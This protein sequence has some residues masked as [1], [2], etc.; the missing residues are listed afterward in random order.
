MWCNYW[1]IVSV[2][3][4]FSYLL[5][6]HC[7]LVRVHDQR[8]NMHMWGLRLAK[9]LF[10][11]SKVRK[12]QGSI[13]PQNPVGTSWQPRL[14]QSPILRSKTLL[15]I[16]KL[17][18]QRDFFK[19]LYEIVKFGSNWIKRFRLNLNRS[20]SKILA[21]TSCRAVNRLFWVLLF[22]KRN[23]GIFIQ[24]LTVFSLAEIGLTINPADSSIH[25]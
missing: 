3:T 19:G 2:I 9:Q 23:S 10:T 6:A 5:I 4:H 20:S 15:G 7:P 18:E 8:E 11:S 21:T 16:A 22:T 17:H 14:P 25:T 13:D 12:P 1:G 24:G